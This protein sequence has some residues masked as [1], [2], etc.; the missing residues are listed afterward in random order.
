MLE[1]AILL[2][3]GT[4]ELPASGMPGLKGWMF[5]LDH[6]FSEASAAQA[7]S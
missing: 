2:D 1:V 6:L 5:S 4:M 3:Q 7:W